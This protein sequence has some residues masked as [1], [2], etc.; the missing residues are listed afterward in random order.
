MSCFCVI[1][2]F[3]FFVYVCACIWFSKEDTINKKTS[4]QKKKLLII[5]NISW[6]TKKTWFYLN[7]SSLN[8]W[9]THSSCKENLKQYI[10]K[11]TTHSLCKKIVIEINHYHLDINDSHFEWKG[12]LRTTYFVNNYNILSTNFLFIYTNN[13]YVYDILH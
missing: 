10:R 5:T 9:W 1:C 3:C 4:R 11:E 8:E 7:Y 12:R 2:I 13:E 6:G